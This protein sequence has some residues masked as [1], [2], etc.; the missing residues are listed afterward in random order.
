MFVSS[1]NSYVEPIILNVMVFGDGAP[2]RSLSIDEVVKAGPH[3]GIS[4]F[5]RRKENKGL[6]IY[7]SL[8]LFPTIYRCPLPYVRTVK[9]HQLQARRALIGS[10]WPDLD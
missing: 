5:I 6:D 1:Q 10:H 7:L 4:V 9:K 2:G 8:S 3:D